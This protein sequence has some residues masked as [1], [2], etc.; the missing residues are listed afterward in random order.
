[1]SAL[2]KEAVSASVESAELAD[3]WV[4]LNTAAELR[5]KARNTVLLEALDGK[6]RHQ[7][8]AGRRFFHRS[9]LEILASLGQSGDDEDEA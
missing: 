2:S 6:I 7:K 8:V 3:P 4:S 1:M 9:D 5:G